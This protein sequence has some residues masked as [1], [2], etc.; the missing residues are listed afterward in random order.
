MNP[1]SPQNISRPRYR[2]RGFALVL[3]LSIMALLIVLVMGFFSSMTS[4]SVSS[5]HYAAASNARR[6]AESGLGMVM[7]QI[8]LATSGS[9]GEMTWTSQPGLLR[10]FDSSGSAKE[11]FK[12]YSAATLRSAAN[13]YSESDDG[14][15]DWKASP[16][17]K[18]RY[19]DINQ[20][21]MSSSGALV[22]PIVDPKAQQKD[23]NTGRKIVSGFQLG[24]SPD[25]F[26]PGFDATIAEGPEN[27]PAAMPVQWLYV[28]QD[29]QI[30][31][32]ESVDDNGNVKF[33]VKGAT[34]SRA[35]PVEGRVAFWT[36]DETCKVNINTA[37]YG[38]NDDTYWTYWDT[39]VQ[40]SQEEETFLSENQPW[41]G[42]YQRYPGHPAT[43]GLN[44]CLPELTKDQIFSFT[45]RLQKGGSDGGAKDMANGIGFLNKQDRLYASLDEALYNP[46]R[47][48]NLGS[49]TNQDL[50]AKRFF[51]TAHSRAPELNLFGQ[52]RVTIWPVPDLEDNRTALDKLIAFCG[53]IG[54]EKF[55]FT[56]SDPMSPTADYGL[57]GNSKVYEYLQ[58]M[59]S[60]KVPGFGGPSMG[61]VSKYGL[62]DC[63]Q[64]LTGIYDTIRI[65][66]LAEM[67]TGWTS[68][69][70]SGASGWPYTSNSRIGQIMGQV[71]PIEN[72]NGTRGA[73]RINVIVEAALVFVN[74]DSTVVSGTANTPGG[75][76]FKAS[77]QSKVLMGILFKFYQPAAGAVGGG[78][79]FNYTITGLQSFSATSSGNK[80]TLFGTDKYTHAMR[81]YSFGAAYGGSNIRVNTLS[82][83]I[84]NK[85]SGNA[86]TYDMPATS[87]LFTV[88][89]G[90]FQFNGGKITV[91][92]RT[93]YDASTKL[94]DPCVQSYTF[95]F[96][97]VASLP[98]PGYFPNGDSMSVGPWNKLTAA[99]Q[100]TSSF[101]SS[102]KTFTVNGRFL[103]TS[104]VNWVGLRDV[105]RSMQVKN[106]DVRAV[107]YLR[108]PSA[109]FEKAGGAN[110][111][112]N[113]WQIHGLD[114]AGS[115]LGEIGQN[116]H[117]LLNKFGCLIKGLGDPLSVYYRIY[118]VLPIGIDG[119]TNNAGE[120][121]DWDNGFAWL[122][123]GAY[124]PK[125][126]EGVLY[127][128]SGGAEQWGY[129]VKNNGL[130][131]MM[132]LGNSPTLFS[133]NRQLPSAVL[134][135]SLPTGVQR[136]L[137][138][139]TLLFRPA[140]SYHMG[141]QYHPGTQAP[142]DH[143]LLDLFQM[144]V[145]EPYAISEPLS[146]AGKVNLNYR[147]KPFDKYLTR[148]TAVRSVLDSVQITA[149]PR[150]AILSPNF[151]DRTNVVDDS[152]R[153]YQGHTRWA[154]DSEETMKFF[155]ERFN[156]NNPVF[157]SESE[158]CNVD[159]VPKGWQANAA[160]LQS[161]WNGTGITDPASKRFTGDN[162]R[163]R[164]YALLYPRF[165]TKSN[166]YTV[167]VVA[168]SLKTPRA[169][170]TG[171]NE[172]AGSMVGEWRGEYTIERYVDPKDSAMPKFLDADGDLSKL[173]KFRTLNV[174]RFD[175]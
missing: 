18:A 31:V 136:G 29:G 165:T 27:N 168:Q 8:R 109:L 17:Y 154:I 114:N 76:S 47:Q 59:T 118:P 37:G 125:P 10:T 56:R 127:N 105:V 85:T 166:T 84:V 61:F 156:S 164:P 124:L 82:D 67:G 20:P 121:G 74:M 103:G 134:F 104:N 102:R 144:P 33:S 122:P 41:K 131:K 3:V 63:N 141:G 83:N 150:A 96:P 152:P 68:T 138:W 13:V 113:A 159:L 30:A 55:Y 133:A 51:M 64:I 171:W 161:F 43:T 75:I 160:S 36:D 92:I 11:V 158:I 93:P 111:D 88:V 145:V 110:Y 98:T 69:S 32:P 71:V 116:T 89:G 172:K 101:D 77:D 23:A 107:A 99:N 58:R 173:Y 146:T 42:E 45:P 57:S 66:N 86:V 21:A 38:V 120:E 72:P 147:I 143:L 40:M 97:A 167:Y 115:G 87:D 140:R 162:S 91:K 54:S 4:E 106:G 65:T 49:L 135:G 130:E 19:A 112:G 78:L 132:W 28:L 148:N 5:G 95:D 73:G 14:V 81:E 48:A 174:K 22:Y 128:K 153:M 129:F 62:A 137:P 126:D 169:Y 53:K 157:V 60:R 142:A 117:S 34:P 50:E 24:S 15:T 155:E 80:Q 52:P 139:Q 39:P 26:A 70:T 170:Q 16:G 151:P 163:E 9:V 94:D 108:D 79:D 2:K 1:Y 6:L 175:P 100:P 46:S 119:V 12:L 25:N 35:N 44:L 90:A 7:S 123:D 149:V